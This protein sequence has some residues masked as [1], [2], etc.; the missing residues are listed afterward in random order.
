MALNI[1]HAPSAKVLLAAN[2]WFRTIR[3]RTLNGDINEDSLDQSLYSLSDDDRAALLAAGYRDV[4]SGNPTSVTTPF[5]YWRCIAQSLQ[6][7]E[8]AEKCNGLLNRTLGKQ[9]NYGFSGQVTWFGWFRGHRNQMTAGSTLDR[10]MLDFR[11]TSQLGYLAPDR[12]VVGVDAFGD[13][14]T[15]GTVDGEPYDTRVDL[16]GLVGTMSLFATDTLS[17]GNRWALTLSGRYNRTT[18][19]NRDR[20]NPSGG[21]NPVRG[22]LDG[23]HSFSR[24]NPSVGLTYRPTGAFNLYASY[25]EGNRAPTS[26][27]LGCADPE[28]PCKL[29]NAMA[30]DPPLAQVVTHTF[31]AGIRSS[32]EGRLDWS[33][34][35][36]HASNQNDILFVASAQTG[37]GYFRNFGRTLRKGIEAEVNVRIWRLVVGN[38]FTRLD[39][40]FA[41]P[42]MVNGESNSSNDGG[43]P[44]LEG[45][46]TVAPGSRIPLIPR[47]L[48]KAFVD[49]SATS[50]LTLNFG[51]QAQSKSIARG[52]E[53]NLHR[54]DGEYYLGDGYSP[55]FAVAQAGA[56]FRIGSHLEIHA[57]ISN[58]FNRR[59]STAAQ[60][61][62]LGFNPEG[63]FQARPFGVNDDGEYPLQHSTFLAPGAPRGIWG[64]VRLRL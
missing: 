4:P 35:G 8:P 21:P 11:Q 44:G 36:F 1:R 56:R 40:T 24:I 42:E 59:Y 17:V 6:R 5:P 55:G 41:S 7:D 63:I 61:G 19:D 47:N 20:I 54:P 9:Y 33:L 25:A 37:F 30:G 38:S 13:G 62:P 39:A 16:R 3:T 28:V 48:Y 51:I 52:N 27:E 26:V 46:I 60:L 15:G 2:G 31:E 57:R 53:N 14:V 10:S 12:G 43:E 22:S 34:G 49:L 18:I 29:P 23:R 45:R 32:R 50:R 64:G 58:L